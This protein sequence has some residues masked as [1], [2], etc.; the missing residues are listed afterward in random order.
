MQRPDGFSDDVLTAS[1]KSGLARG[2][3]FMSHGRAYAFE[4]GTRPSTIGH[5]L[6]TNPVAL[7]SWCGEKFLDWVDEPLPDETILEFV[8]LYWLTETFPRSIYTYREYYQGQRY[9]MTSRWYINKPFGF[10]YFPMELLPVPKSWVDTTG[11]LVF[12]KQHEKGG[13]FAA[14]ERPGQ[15]KADI[16]EFVNQVWPTTN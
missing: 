7:L 9:D 1:E 11:N 10:S 12:W 3:A 13:H 2:S 5:I 16:S 4:H 14:L 6:S 15:M 8:S